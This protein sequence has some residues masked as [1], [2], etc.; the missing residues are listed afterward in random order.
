MSESDYQQLVERVLQNVASPTISTDTGLEAAQIAVKQVPRRGL[1]PVSL[2][3][4]SRFRQIPSHA[5]T[6]RE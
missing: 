4:L 5:K 1:V 6:V 3:S 2:N